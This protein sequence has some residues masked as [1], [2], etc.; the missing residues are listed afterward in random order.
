MPEVALG[1]GIVPEL[2]TR[3]WATGPLLERLK[4]Y[5]S[6]K[7]AG[8]KC[9]GRQVAAGCSAPVGKE[10]GCKDVPRLWRK[11]LGKVFST[12]DALR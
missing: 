6:S 12:A 5:S 1:K 10:V 11:A 4:V 8:S 7:D 2:R 3:R 9:S